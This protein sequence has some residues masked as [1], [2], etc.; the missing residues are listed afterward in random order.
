MSSPFAPRLG[1]NYCPTDEEVLEISSLL[2]DSTF[3]LKNLDDK[4]ADLQQALDKLVEER[5]GLGAYMESH[6]ALIS[7]VRRLPL[8]IIEEIFVAC[9]PTHRN[10]VTSATE[11]PLLL[12]HICSAWRSI[13][14]STPQLWASLHLV[15]PSAPPHSAHA[16]E[17][18][19]FGERVTRRLEITTTWLGRSGQCPLSLSIESSPEEGTIPEAYQ[20]TVRF[21][22]ALIPFA[23]RW[24]HVHFTSPPRLLFEIISYLDIDMPLLETVEFHHRSRRPP[25]ILPI[26][27]GSFEM[28]G[29]ARIS[30]FSISGDLF[31]PDIFPLRWNQ[32]TTLTIGGPAHGFG[33]GSQEFKGE[34]MLPILSKCLQLRHCRLMVTDTA[35]LGDSDP[36]LQQPTVVLPFLQTLAVHCVAYAAS[37]VSALQHFSFPE[38]RHFALVG[39]WKEDCP[40]FAD[41]VASSTHLESLDIASNLFWKA[42]FLEII[43]RLPA[44]IQRLKIRDLEDEWQQ[45]PSLDEDTLVLLANAGLCPALQDLSV[46]RGSSIPDAAVLWFITTRMRQSRPTLRRVDIQFFRPMKLDIMP[47]LQALLKTGLAVCLTYLPP[48]PSDSQYSY[49]PWKGLADE[50]CALPSMNDW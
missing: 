39:F 32:L 12:G 29:G 34:M 35:D 38:L 5:D 19:E 49:S 30:S 8:D 13:S 48:R 18:R 3:R 42:P 1:T 33:H 14:L 16:Q 24:Q 22:Q 45:P 37:A 4:I 21:F 46:D 11:A 47:D 23:G 28:L 10:C 36:A 44:T 40:A 43:G 26:I 20:A 25:Q 6:K 9:L 27:C 17:V 50:P 15:E 41:F 31:I 2:V 7:P